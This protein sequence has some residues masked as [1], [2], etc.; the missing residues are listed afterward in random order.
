V[1]S[2]LNLHRYRDLECLQQIAAYLTEQ[3]SDAKLRLQLTAVGIR[4]MAG[5]RCADCTMT[6]IQ[7]GSLLSLSN[8]VQ[9]LRDAG[10]G[11]L[12]NQRLVNAPPQ[13][14]PPLMQA[15]FDEI[16]WAVEDEPTRASAPKT[17]LSGTDPH[18][19][20]SGGA[21]SAGIMPVPRFSRC[22]SV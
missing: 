1:A 8:T 2:V 11:L 4:C 21:Q 17:L 19:D 14:A 7:F 15:L 22:Q 6:C 10:S 16:S 3:C 20:Q 13:V 18:S 5:N 12:L 9:A